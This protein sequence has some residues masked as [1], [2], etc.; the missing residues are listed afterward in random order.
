M[1]A[2][3]AQPKPIVLAHEAPFTIGDLTVR[4]ETCELSG[5]GGNRVLEPRVMQVLV[6]LYQADGHVVSRDDL[7]QRCWSGRIV[8]EDAIHRVISRLRHEAEAAGAEFRIETITKVGYRLVRT[9]HSD[10]ALSISAPSLQP[11][12][13]SLNRRAFLVGAGGLVTVVAGGLA[14]QRWRTPE[15]PAEAAAKIRDGNELW[16]L[17]SI[18][19]FAA[20]QSA[21]REAAALAPD[22]AE[23]W[24]YLAIS[25]SYQAR[26]GPPSGYADTIRQSRA[27]MARAL[28]IDPNNVEALCAGI[29]LDFGRMDYPIAEAEKRLQAVLR[30]DPRSPTALRMQCYILDQV[31]RGNAS[32]ASFKV[33]KDVDPEL[34]AVTAAA[35]A[36]D[37]YKAGR[38]DEADQVLEEVLGRWPR[39]TASWFTKLKLLM[40]TRRFER[41]LA[42]L[43][44]SG[45]RP[46][47]VPEWNFALTRSQ[48]LGLANPA[49]NLSKA[50]AET[51][52]SARKG[53]GFAENAA[54]YLSANNRLDDAFAVSQALL[55]GKG[56]QVSSQRFTQEQGHFDN[57]RRRTAYLFEPA[58]APMRK[59]PRFAELTRMTGLDDYWR[60]SGTKPDYRA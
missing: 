12:S 35:Y 54:L 26:T 15:L 3:V 28:A 51:M 33:L 27:S 49:A 36:Y 2:P 43:D 32:L 39:H 5:N 21:F 19:S 52:E 56:F 29:S 22:F 16:R 30:H 48:I 44:D 7:L 14:W 4:P 40:Y 6:A 18:E 57:R 58:T 55:E 1:D 47:G 20:A 45:R 23:P 9:G 8:G 60:A 37:L 24:G 53:T 17:G 31:G 38:I 34:D 41:A 59:D 42:M 11:G 50:L 13:P 46:V 10:P 25:Y